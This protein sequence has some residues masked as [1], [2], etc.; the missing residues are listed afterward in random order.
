M[1]YRLLHYRHW[2]FQTNPIHLINSCLDPAEQVR[3]Q[4]SNPSLLL[5]AITVCPFSRD[6]AGWKGE[7]ALQWFLKDI[8]D[9]AQ[10][11]EE[12]K[13]CVTE[14][15]YGLNET[16]GLDVDNRETGLV[17][18]EGKT[19]KSALSSHWNSSLTMTMLGICQTMAYPEP[20]DKMSSFQVTLKGNF[21]VVLHDPNFFLIKSDNF[22][23][24]YLNLNNPTGKGY[25]LKVVTKKRM[26]RAGKF[27]CNPDS[28]Y[29]FGTCVK[30]SVAKSIGCNSPW[31]DHSVGTLPMCSSIKEIEDY[32]ALF[33]KMLFADQAVLQNLTGC[34]VPCTYQ[35][36]SL[37]G[38]SLP[39]KLSENQLVLLFVTTDILEDEE[40]FSP[41][42]IFIT[43]NIG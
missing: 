21:M 13:R 39:V 37:M 19:F 2:R 8:C 15:S 25:R 35:D 4:T 27:D 43:L 42:T 23:I 11:F 40:V 18:D 32:E 31:T 14:K 29:N 28:G 12:L 33:N 6:M 36:F 9:E 30:A 7:T 22:F 10:T 24:P 26:N 41:I 1:Y 16:V 38:S 17:S 5:P 34:L 20:V 3:K